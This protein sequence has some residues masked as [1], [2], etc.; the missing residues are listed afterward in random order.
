MKLLAG[1]SNQS[2]AAAIGDYLD[3]APIV[4]IYFNTHL[5]LLQT[6]V[7]GWLPTPMDHTDYRYVSLQP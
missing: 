1:N 3:A 4:P 5:Y 2:L 6:S 7:K